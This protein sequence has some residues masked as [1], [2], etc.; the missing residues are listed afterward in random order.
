MKR[1]DGIIVPDSYDRYEQ[2]QAQLTILKRLDDLEAEV[3]RLHRL[4][5]K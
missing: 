2:M 4:L 3:K 5:D 1:Q